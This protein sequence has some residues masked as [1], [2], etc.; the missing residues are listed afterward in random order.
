MIKRTTGTHNDIHIEHLDDCA[1]TLRELMDANYKEIASRW[2]LRHTDGTEVFILTQYGY[3]FRLTGKEV[4]QYL[5][6]RAVTA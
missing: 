5:A 4:L 3:E 1:F 2:N 6:E